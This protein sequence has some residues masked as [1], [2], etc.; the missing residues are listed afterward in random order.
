[1]DLP[2][3]AA[4]MSATL[5]FA[6]KAI[7]SAE[8][9]PKKIAGLLG[10][11]TATMTV[12]TRFGC[13]IAK[14]SNVLSSERSLHLESLLKRTGSILKII[15]EDLASISGAKTFKILSLQKVGS[16]KKSTHEL[17]YIL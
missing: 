13:L 5:D 7:V 10:S 17:K 1:M 11:L 14:D 16:L 8:C 4:S 3:L 2:A 15:S 6:R 9:Y 12:Y